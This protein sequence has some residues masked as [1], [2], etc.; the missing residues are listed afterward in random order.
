MLLANPKGIASFLLL[1]LAI[2]CRIRI[3][4]SK[5]PRLGDIVVP[6]AFGIL[7]CAAM[8]IESHC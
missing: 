8:P 7:D 1:R 6:L 3:V 4:R 2:E 5:A